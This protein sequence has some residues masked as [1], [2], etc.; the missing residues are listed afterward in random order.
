MSVWVSPSTVPMTML[1]MATVMSTG[2]QSQRTPSKATVSTRRI[3][4]NAATLVQVAMKAV[5]GV[6]APWYTSGVHVWNGPTEALNSSP[7][8]SSASPANSR[9]SE[10]SEP[11]VA[12][13]M[14]ASETVPA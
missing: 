1:R 2:R 12:V 13:A 7:T 4:P 8:S 3:A 5:I 10:R 6:G 9:V 14:P 11:P